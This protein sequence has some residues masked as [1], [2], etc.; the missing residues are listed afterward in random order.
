MIVG[1]CRFSYLAK[2]GWA[3]HSRSLEQQA[4]YLYDPERMRKRLHLFGT[5]TLPSMLRQTDQ[6]FKLL[7]LTS[8]HMPER[9]VG[10][11]K[12]LI[13]GA[14]NVE[15]VMRP[16]RPHAA[17]LRNTLNEAF[18]DAAVRISF[19]LDDDDAV[20]IRFIE[21]LRAMPVQ[22]PNPFFVSFSQGITVMNADGRM[23]RAAIGELPFCSAG[24]TLFAQAPV[25]EVVYDHP[26]QRCYAHR[27]TWV[28]SETPMFI[29]NLHDDN[30]SGP[31]P[32]G[33]AKDA[34]ETP[35]ALFARVAKDFP[36]IAA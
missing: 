28:V 27:P 18:G 26:H 24:L 32:H 29:R 7:V 16:P 4:A 30:D 6:D 17:A 34:W 12:D 2:G 25:T 31:T 33:V 22:G 13:G 23:Q 20:S 14:P 35:Q 1:L 19:R 11:L 36:Y 5:F 3:R 15:L 21:R 8:P 10:E 9:F